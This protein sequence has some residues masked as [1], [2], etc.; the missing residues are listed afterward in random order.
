MPTNNSPVSA[1]IN[2]YINKHDDIK[3]HYL[4]PYSHNN[5]LI[6]SLQNSFSLSL[7]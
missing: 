2:P 5:V 6:L 1:C 7:S 4:N 3:N